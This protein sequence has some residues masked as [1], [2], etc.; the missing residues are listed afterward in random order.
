[1]KPSFSLKEACNQQLGAIGTHDVNPQGR[2][3]RA[4]DAQFYRSVGRSID[5]RFP[6]RRVSEPV[7]SLELNPVDKY[8]FCARKGKKRLETHTSP[9][10]D[11]ECGAQPARLFRYKTLTWSCDPLVPCLILNPHWPLPRAV[12][13]HLEK[14]GFRIQTGQ[15]FALRPYSA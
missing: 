12:S 11:V 9:R 6:R 1:M 2:Y 3:H 14:V 5:P 8:L 15:P 7:Y 13:F 10:A 4:T